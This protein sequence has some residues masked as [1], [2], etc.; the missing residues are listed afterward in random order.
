MAS[1]CNRNQQQWTDVTNHA[2]P[3][4]ERVALPPRTSALQKAAAATLA[5]DAC[6]DIP[7][8]SGTISTAAISYY[9]NIYD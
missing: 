9:T 6:R 2:G 1:Q 7:T 3:H 4:Y 5:T 8:R